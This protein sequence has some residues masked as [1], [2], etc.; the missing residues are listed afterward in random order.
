MIFPKSV[1][2]HDYP[3]YCGYRKY[4]ESDFEL[5]QFHF[6]LS[7]LLLMSIE[8]TMIRT[9][10]TVKSASPL[11]SQFWLVSFGSAI[12][13]LHFTQVSIVDYVFSFFLFFKYSNV[14]MER[15]IIKVRRS[16][17]AIPICPI[18]MNSIMMK[19][20]R[21]P[22]IMTKPFGKIT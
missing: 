18:A 14:I 21:A 13:F 4:N 20:Q 16:S 12:T 6:H 7:P 5:R 9:E 1:T 17:S 19:I 22:T 11:P 10:R 2:E 8:L 15:G 3:N